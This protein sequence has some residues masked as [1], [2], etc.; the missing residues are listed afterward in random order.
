MVR[1]VERLNEQLLRAV[2]RQQELGV[3][4]RIRS[5]CCDSCPR[6]PMVEGHADDEITARRQHGVRADEA[7]DLAFAAGDHLAQLERRESHVVNFEYVVSCVV[8]WFRLNMWSVVLSG[9]LGL[10]TW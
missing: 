7:A 2:E 4:C 6:V 8:T 9:G 5:S 1:G 10:N 3:S